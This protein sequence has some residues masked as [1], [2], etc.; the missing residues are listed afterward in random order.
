M[1]FRVLRNLFVLFI[2]TR[3]ACSCIQNDDST[4]WNRLQEHEDKITQL[5]RACKSI[6]S[7]IEALPVILQS[8][9]NGDSICDIHS[10]FEDGQE[11][12]YSITF[13]DGRKCV[14]YTNVFSIT[15]IPAIG[16]S[17]DNGVY[18]WTLNDKWLTDSEYN[19]IAVTETSLILR[20]RD[21]KWQQSTDGGINWISLGNCSYSRSQLWINKVWEDRENVYIG[22]DSQTF[23]FPKKSIDNVLNNKVLRV[24]SIGSSFGVNV[25]IQFPSL[26]SSV[27]IDITGTNLYKGSCSLHEMANLCRNDAEFDGSATYTHKTKSWEPS[28]KLVSEVLRSQNWDVIILQR[29]APGQVGGS[30][31]WTEDMAKDLNYILGY[32]ESHALGHPK[33]M[34][35]SSFSRSI[36]LLGSREKQLE[37]VEL[38]METSKKI[39][40]SFG[41]EIIPAAIAIHNARITNLS[42][43][44]TYNSFGYD[45]PDLTG[46]GNHLDTGVGSYILGCLLFEQ[47]CGKRYDLSVLNVPYIPTIEDV[48]GNA[49][50]FNDNNFTQ[51]TPDQAHIAKYAAISAMQSPW[52][53]NESTERLTL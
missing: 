24:L 37:S 40:E 36:C 41:L 26:A 43:V 44:A 31:Q 5:S 4:L 22:L 51:I 30:D 23:V 18:Y 38:I 34:F 9:Q 39:S 42:Q 15:S 47:I 12:G 33:V 45:I 14:V 48:R 17:K 32:I 29:P 35:C 16:L 25:F 52:K 46:E 2:Y 53:V 8:V 13:E 1:H 10:V 50:G 6:N 20:I 11:I 19:R 21:A 27:G 3:L 49:G 7:N 28:S